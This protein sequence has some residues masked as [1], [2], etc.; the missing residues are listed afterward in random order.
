MASP[1]GTSTDTVSE[2]TDAL[3][4]VSAGTSYEERASAAYAALTAGH[5]PQ[6]VNSAYN[7]DDAAD[8]DEDEDST[9]EATGTTPDP[10]PKPDATKAPK[11]KGAK[12]KGATEKA[13]AVLI[14]RRVLMRDGWDAEDLDLLSNERILAKAETRAEHHRTLD[15]RLTSPTEKPADADDD[16]QAQEDRRTAATEPDDDFVDSIR[17][18]DEELAE[19]VNARQ[20]S[21]ASENE[22]LKKQLAVQRLQA[23]VTENRIKYPDL[24]DEKVLDQVLAKARALARSDAYSSADEAFT[25]AC[26]LILGSRREQSAQQRMAKQVREHRNG[27]ID[28]DTVTDDGETKPMTR[29]EKDSYGFRLLSKGKSPA[30]VRSVLARIPEA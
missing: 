20:T 28:T 13:E 5:T 2:A 26:S 30:E 19:K 17:E 16:D 25:D 21:L 1:D 27:Q 8:D 3:E 11:A 15:R 14:A 23:I 9:E 6:A 4:A 10:S 7:R 18:Y 24:G 22:T 29:D 12:D